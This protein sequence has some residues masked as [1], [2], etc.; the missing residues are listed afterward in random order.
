MYRGS[1]TRLRGDFDKLQENFRLV[2][3]H[4]TNAGSSYSDT[5][6]A[7]TKFDAKLSQ[8]EQPQLEARPQPQEG[9]KTP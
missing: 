2:G 8:V 9:L 4:L 6:K 1:L 3:K 5:E 7:L